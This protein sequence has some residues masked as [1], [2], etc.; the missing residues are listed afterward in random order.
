MLVPEPLL[1]AAEEA[2]RRALAVLNRL[3]LKLDVHGKIA[4]LAVITKKHTA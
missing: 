3:E 1:R 2:E 4:E